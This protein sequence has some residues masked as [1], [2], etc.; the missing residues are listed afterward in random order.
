MQKVVKDERKWEFSNSDDGNAN[1]YNLLG[2]QLA[3]SSK[4]VVLHISYDLAILL[5]GI[6]TRKSPAHVYKNSVQHWS[7]QYLSKRCKKES[8]VNFFQEET[9]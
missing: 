1:W 2:E 3:V 4:I 7:L 6:C 8:Y 9:R 5:P